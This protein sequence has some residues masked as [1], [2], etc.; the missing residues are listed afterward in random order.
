MKHQKILILSDVTVGSAVP[1]I[2]LLAQSLA[3]E[4]SAEVTVVEPDMKGRLYFYNDASI[5][6]RRIS[7]RMPP[8]HELFLTE[9]AR[10][11]TNIYNEIEPDI[12]IVMNAAVLPPLLLGRN[13]PKM[14]IYYMLESLDHQISLGGQHFFDMNRMATSLIDLVL[15]PE[16]RRFAVD[17]ARLGWQDLPVIEILNV[18]TN[19]ATLRSNAPN[20]CHFLFAGTLNKATGFDWLTDERL[21]EIHIDVAGPTDSESSKELLAAFLANRNGGGQRRYLGLLPHDELVARMHDYAYRLV[22]WNANDINCFYASPNKY[23][24]SIA[25]HVPPVCSPHPQLLESNSKYRC[26]ILADGFEQEDV[27]HAILDAVSIFHSDG[28][29]RLLQGCAKAANEE[30]RWPHQFRKILDVLQNHTEKGPQRTTFQQKHF[31]AADAL[32]SGRK[33]V[34]ELSEEQSAVS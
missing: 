18:G 11:L 4:L 14:V 22:I 3:A 20:A 33:Q 23:F 6:V 17:S 29:G 5:N 9:Y 8:H 25:N 16:K 21:S 7:T 24:E 10:S 28:Y 19:E 2:T 12:L 15:V 1:Q 34:E 30:Y 31:V 26:S 27:V 13:K 32:A